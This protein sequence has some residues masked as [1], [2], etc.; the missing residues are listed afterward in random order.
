M[1]IPPFPYK[2]NFLDRPEK[3]LQNLSD[4]KFLETVV[5]VK[6]NHGFKF[7]VSFTSKPH[8]YEKI[9]IVTDLFTESA[10]VRANVFGSI[11]PYR[12]WATE[13]SSI[14]AEALKRFGKIDTLSLREAIYFMTKEATAFSPAISKL[15]Y[16]SLLPEGGTVFDPF[17]GW[18][19]RAIGA[20]CCSQV[21][22][23][24]GVDCNPLLRDG[25]DQIQKINP[26]VVLHTCSISKF[27]TDMQF[28]LVF[29]SPPFWDFEI[30]N[31][32]DPDQSIVGFKT[33]REWWNK[34]FVPL[35]IQLKSM[36]KKGGYICLYV[37]TTY[38]TKSMVDD[39]Y[40]ALSSMGCKYIQRID[41]SVEGKRAVPIHI[42]RV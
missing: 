34:F 19:D 11:S 5:T 33:Y 24:V 26:K 23:Y 13:H 2:K 27:K 7:P 16:Q 35:L 41:C 39:I 31:P 32:D 14:H 29:T 10:R 4:D 22:K 36:T 28:D 42:Y 15:L 8:V 38:R 37:G 30:Y 1:E 20:I 40:N 12:F 21:T 25:Y 9:N 6:R 3:Y 18:G 17:A